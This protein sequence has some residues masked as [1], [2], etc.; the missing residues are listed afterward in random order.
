M[1]IGGAS[2]VA[3]TGYGAI[4]A[5]AGAGV[6]LATDLTDM[7]TQNIEKSEIESICSRRN[8]VGNRLTKYF[9]ELQRVATEL[10][11]LNV[12]ESSAYLL[13]IKNIISKGNSI[14]TSAAD[15]LKLS[16]SVQVANGASGMLLRNGGYFW[17]GMRLQSEALMKALAFL[18]FNVSKTGAM[19]VIR[20]STAFLN[21]AFA[22]YDIY[23]LV[24]TVKNNHPTADAIS[25]LIGQMNEELTPIL[26]LRRNAIDIQGK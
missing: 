4:V 10:R 26:E 2:I 17:K 6:N 22:I 5:A 23:S 18:G 25:Q 7:I 16:R 1:F 9:D 24:Q 21:G 8:Q 3:A 15:I 20:S 14:R 19:A 12:E 11:K 13:A